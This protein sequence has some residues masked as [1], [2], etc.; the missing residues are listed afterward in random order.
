[1]RYADKLRLPQWQRARL[2][3]MGRDDFTCRKCHDNLTPLVVH[4]L[5]Y[6]RGR[7]PWEYP[8]DA[9]V[10]LCETCHEEEHEEMR[11][12]NAE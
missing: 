5:Y 4:H 2:K 12:L 1:M 7:D 6:E 10:T 8:D 11:A 9:L 3:I